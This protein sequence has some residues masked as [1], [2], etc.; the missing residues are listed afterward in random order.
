MRI[1]HIS[2]IHLSERN[3]PDFEN[4]FRDALLKVLKLEQEVKAIDVIIITGDLVDQGGHSLLRLEKYS[5]IADPYVI[6]QQEFISPIQEALGFPN[7]KFLFIP[8]NHDINE[9]EILWVEEKKLQKDEVAGNIN[10]YL[11]N[12]KTSFDFSNS[13]IE[14]FKNFEKRFHSNTSD[15]YYSNNESVYIYRHAQGYNVGFALINDSWRC[16]TCKL[17]EHRSKKLYFGEQQLYHSIHTIAKFGTTCNVILTHH[18]LDMYEEREDVFNTLVSSDFHLH[19]FGDQHKQKYDPY[20]S[21]QGSCFGIMARAGFNNPKETESV[22]QPGF[23]IIDISI[24]KANIEKITYYKYV[25]RHRVFALDS[26][27]APPDGYDVSMHS[28]SFKPNYEAS[29]IKV[30]ELD[31]SKF[32]R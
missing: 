10:T 15:Y 9:N 29:K 3:F 1:V 31:K 24:D 28:L 16:S 13:R 8:G 4:K 22:W 6:F 25:D 17:V 30:K 2:D 11:I 27:T 32:I 19:L 12:N 21:A 20:L 18:P 7:S 26:E 14:L 23:Q 5:G